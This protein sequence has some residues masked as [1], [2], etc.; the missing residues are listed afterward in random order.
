M[1][2]ANTA[3][4]LLLEESSGTSFSTSSITP[5]GDALVLATVTTTH[6]T[7]ASSPSSV[8]GNGLTWVLVDSQAYTGDTFE[9]KVSVYRAMGSSP[10]SGAVTVNFASS[11]D[12]YIVS[13]T[14]FTGVDTTGTNGSGAV[15]QSTTNTASADNVDIDLATFGSVDNYA[16]SCCGINV[17]DPVVVPTGFTTIHADL[18]ESPAEV[19]LHTAYKSN[20][21]LINWAT[22]GDP[23]DVAGVSVEIKA[24]ATS[25]TGTV[26]VTDVD[27]TISAAGT[28]LPSTAL[29]F[30]ADNNSRY[31]DVDVA[32][33]SLVL[34]DADW[35][36]GM[37]VR[38]PEG[39]LT[40]MD[41]QYIFSAGT[42]GT[43]NSFHIFFGETSNFRE[44]IVRYN[45]IT[46]TEVNQ[47]V[48]AGVGDVTTGIDNTDH[49]LVIQR[50]GTTT[51]GYWIPE[52]D[53]VS[54]ADNSFS[55]NANTANTFPTLNIG[56]RPDGN[57]TRYFGNTV[58]EVF[59]LTNDSLSNTD[60]TT[61]AEGKHITIVRS[62][63]E[64]DLR[65]RG[66]NATEVDL[67]DNGFDGTRTGTGYNLLAEFFPDGI[68]GTSNTTDVNDT[69][70][71]AGTHST[72]S[73]TQA[74]LTNAESQTNGT[75][76]TT[77][78]VSPTGDYLQLL[79][80][81]GSN[82]GGGGAPAVPSI[83]GNGLTWVLIAE[84]DTD[85]SY[86]SVFLFR[87]M[88]ASPSTG[89]IT[90][91]Y[92]ETMDDCQW[93]L[94]E[95]TGVD[96]GG[97]NG[98]AAIVQSAV[99]TVGVT[100]SITATLAAF[101]SANNATYGA[102]GQLYA[103]DG[104]PPSA[105][106][107]TGFTEITEDGFDDGSYTSG[108]QTQ[109]RDDNDTTVDIT[110][111]SS[112][113]C[114][115]VA[116]EIKAGAAAAPTGTVDVTDVD[117]TSTTAGEQ[118]FTGTA[119][120]TDVDDVTTTAG[121]QTYL[122]TSDTTDV[123]DTSTAAGEVIFIGTA[124]TTDVDD[125]SA[126]AGELIFTGTLNTTDVDDIIA[127]S[128]EQ[129]TTGT[130]NTTDV[131]DTTA[132]AGTQHYLGTSNTTDVDDT[133]TAVGKSTYAGTLVETDVDDT[134]SASGLMQPSGI[135]NVTDV[136]DTSTT[137]G[138]QTYLGTSDTTDVDDTISATGSA[139]DNTNGTVDVTDV[140]DTSTTAGTQTYLGTLNTTDVDDTST[141]AGEQIF[142]GTA[143]T[144][145]VDDT[146]TTAGTQNY[147]GTVDV[148]DVDD[149]TATAGTQHY[150]GTVDVT[151]VDDT[152]ATA[153][154]VIFTGTLVETDVDDTIASSGI[155]QPSGALDTTDIDDTITA[156]GIHSEINTL[157]VLEEDDETTTAGTQTYLGTVDVTDVDDTTSTAGEVIF[158]G[159]SD[160]TDNDDVT[161][162][163]GIIAYL[164]I[165]DTTDV[166]DTISAAGT[167]INS[168][169]GTLD[170]TEEEDTSSTAGT[171]HYLGTV[172]VTEENDLPATA[173]TQ[174]YLGTVD[175][176][177]VDDTSTATGE[178]IF[179]GTANTTDIDDTSTTAGTQHYLGTVN[180]TEEDDVA[181]AA[182]IILNNIIGTL[183]VVEDN[184]VITAT[185]YIPALYSTVVEDITYIQD[186]YKIIYITTHD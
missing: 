159:T 150:L 161:N 11:Q 133:T 172:D 28:S 98:S 88:G 128:G 56:R 55:N 118:I 107:G 116:V 108:L 105:T 29:N 62:D 22:T 86:S 158:T 25:F 180:E 99:N 54:G 120:T 90:I 9:G 176:T 95:F 119:N 186:K 80:V 52:G 115:V 146:S 68:L 67:S 177:D 39:L 109:W 181:T 168:S 47:L 139:L 113:D 185:G 19:A 121:T 149:T 97:T 137:A 144:T 117:D 141:T 111:D 60:L 69:L 148:T 38:M 131:D 134:I 37:W 33:T 14:E 92:A 178:L 27:D 83:S 8:T 125:T 127:A 96:T 64:L 162:A 156:V 51:Y 70:A 78:S 6:A 129:I 154:E 65:F 18:I 184:D 140:D 41:Y 84:A 74:L 73:V 79:A 40:T 132:T 85:T 103:G 147:L 12:G 24:G 165:L 152:T 77:A 123:D 66:D 122:G 130:S 58:G 42:I 71:G 174:T 35:C 46:G 3:L 32:T 31:F 75:G 157:N 43:S 102:F 81:H 182:G 1:A 126:T 160:T 170:V 44:I 21:N 53:T 61:L 57:T 63:A 166:D 2:I 7:V 136:D 36:V 10:T 135:V 151:D 167:S 124:N 171:Q 59:I 153:S 169:S 94:S 101:G 34:P 142:T 13:V 145:D 87:A 138:T 76:F 15:V 49:L 143:N 16:Y 100:A 72:T 112:Y 4:T 50:I 82:T 164:A 93:S 175:V 104:T 89:T 179:I 183:N 45:G 155:M 48:Y 23:Q 5:T 106:P 20:D 173:G 30:G 17:N 91:T 110:W 26:D 163:N 114:G